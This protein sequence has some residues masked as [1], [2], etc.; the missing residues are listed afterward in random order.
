MALLNLLR[1][2]VF[3]TQ[4]INS[5]AHHFSTPCPPQD[6]PLWIMTAAVSMCVLVVTF[7]SVAF[8]SRWVCVSVWLRRRDRPLPMYYE[9]RGLMEN[10][11]C[12]SRMAALFSQPY[13]YNHLGVW[14]L[15]SQNQYPR[16]MRR[17]DTGAGQSR[18][19]T[20]HNTSTL[21]LLIIFL[22]CFSCISYSTG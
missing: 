8:Y 11:G 9:E 12:R 15:H 22:L 7:I 1:M 2:Q 6:L 18:K 20:R 17:V 5:S 3:V 19:R 16:G 10:R 14:P 13:Q 21:M 4:P